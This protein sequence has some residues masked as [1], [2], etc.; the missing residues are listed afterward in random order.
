MIMLTLLVVS[1]FLGANAADDEL[2]Q[3]RLIYNS[4]GQHVHSH[5][6]ADEAGRRVQI[7]PLEFPSP[8]C[9]CLATAEMPASP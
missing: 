8:N 5:E 2:R 9:G 4:D 7:R 1:G 3:R 6:T